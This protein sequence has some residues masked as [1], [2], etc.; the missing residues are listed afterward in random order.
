MLSSPWRWGWP[1]VESSPSPFSQLWNSCKKISNSSH[2]QDQTFPGGNR[3]ACW[4]FFDDLSSSAITTQWWRSSTGR[5]LAKFGYKKKYESHGFLGNILQCFGYP[6]WTPCTE[7]R[8]A[9]SWILFWI[10]AI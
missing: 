7:I 2:L 1:P 3:S 5:S 4:G 10:L 6:T 9:F 8:L